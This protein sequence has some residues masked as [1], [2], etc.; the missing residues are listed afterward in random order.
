MQKFKLQNFWE[1]PLYEIWECAFNQP[2]LPLETTHKW[3]HLNW[4]FAKQKQKTKNKK[5]KQKQK[6][7]QNMEYIYWKVGTKN[8]ITG[9]C[10]HTDPCILKVDSASIKISRIF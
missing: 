4:N 3:R 9:L 2:S 6:K 10:T 7:E 1:C 8:V 5:Q